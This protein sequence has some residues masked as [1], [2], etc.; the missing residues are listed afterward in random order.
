MID[1]NDLLVPR[2][3]ASLDRRHARSVGK[4]SLIAD[5]RRTQTRSQGNS[6]FIIVFAA[7]A[8]HAKHFHLRAKRRNIHRDIS[9]AT[10]TLALLDEI[11]HRHR[12]LRRQPRRSSPQIA[13]QHQV[14]E[15]ADTLAR[16]AR[17]SRLRFAMEAGFDRGTQP[18]EVT[19]ARFAPP[20][21]A[22]REYRRESDRRAGTIRTSNRFCPVADGRALCT[23]G[24]AEYRAALVKWPWASR[25]KYR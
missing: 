10:Q 4:H 1:A 2:N 22:S 21:Q 20:R 12:R 13:V 18:R 6:R 25:E 14:A 24:N 16:D 19:Q 11:D 15:H 9:G 5:V 17:I 7:R 8:H 3:D 23:R